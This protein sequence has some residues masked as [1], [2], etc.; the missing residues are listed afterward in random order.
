MVQRMNHLAAM[1]AAIETDENESDAKTEATGPVARPT[2]RQ[3]PPTRGTRK[4]FVEF[5]SQADVS[6]YGINP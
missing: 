3:R 2:R 1:E 5:R 4:I 6:N